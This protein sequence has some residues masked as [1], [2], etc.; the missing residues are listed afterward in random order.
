MM[1]DKFKIASLNVN[2]I[3]DTW[4]RDR[5]FHLLNDKE[6]YN[7]DIILLQETKLS[8]EMSCLA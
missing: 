8:K 1:T 4:K 2:G 6:L 5:T 7:F 3:N